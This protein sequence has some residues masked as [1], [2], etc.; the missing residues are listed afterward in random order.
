M[1][2]ALVPP[3]LL[4]LL[5]SPTLSLPGALEPPLPLCSRS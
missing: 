3:L 5:V 2:P 4:L 1:L